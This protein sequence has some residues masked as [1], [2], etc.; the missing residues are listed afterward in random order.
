MQQMINL[1]PLTKRI[2]TRGGHDGFF[3]VFDGSKRYCEIVSK[4]CLIH[5][6]TTSVMLVVFSLVIA[7][8]V[9]RRL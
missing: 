9:V 3:D 4:N 8:N 2:R 7:V 6:K 5:K 1:T